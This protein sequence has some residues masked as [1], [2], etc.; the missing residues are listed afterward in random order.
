MGSTGIGCTIN[1][2]ARVKIEPSFHTKIFFNRKEVNFPTVR[3]AISQLTQKPIHVYITSP[4]PLG[5][6]FGLSAASTLASLL[7]TNQ[8]F[9]LKKTREELIKIAHIA[10]IINHTGLGS[11]GTQITGGFLM[12][13]SPGIP[14][15]YTRLP[16]E[17][18]TVYAIIIDKLETP[19]I[20]KDK[21]ILECVNEAADYTIKK[22]KKIKSITLAEIFDISFAFAEESTI[23]KEEKILSLIKKIKSKGGHA[24]MAML[25]QVV[26]SDIKPNFETKYHIEKLTISNDVVRL[27]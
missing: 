11:V 18:K 8:Y 24:T 7:A 12:K 23:L 14:V 5:F 10:E 22:I 4:L 21:R 26:L 27:L 25:G 2:G 15:D 20:L 16:F 3:Y 1:K 9:F 13:N 19:S 6:G 17:G